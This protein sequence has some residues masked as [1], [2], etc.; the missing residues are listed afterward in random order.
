MHVI[1]STVYQQLCFAQV[2]VFYWI[3]QRCTY[4]KNRMDISQNAETFDHLAL[5]TM[6]SALRHG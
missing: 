1:L 3:L 4:F 6:L 2:F 5:L